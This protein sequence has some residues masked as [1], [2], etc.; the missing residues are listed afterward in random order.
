MLVCLAVPGEHQNQIVVLNLAIGY[1]CYDLVLR[2]A[3][4][5]AEGVT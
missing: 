4:C 1:A 5:L 2:T 3:L